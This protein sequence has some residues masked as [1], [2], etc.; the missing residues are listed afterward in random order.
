MTKWEYKTI[1][2]DGS[3]KLEKILN[4]LGNDG[5]E[6]VIAYKSRCEFCDLLILKKQKLH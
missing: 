2:W 1:K 4:E 3:I 5:W 6:L